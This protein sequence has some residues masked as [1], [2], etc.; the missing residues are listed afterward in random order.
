MRRHVLTNGTTNHLVTKNNGD[1]DHRRKRHNHERLQETMKISRKIIIGFACFG[2]LFLLIIHS[3][4]FVVVENGNY[5]RKPSESIRI[6]DPKRKETNHP[7]IEEFQ[8]RHFDNLE[9][10]QL[11]P[12]RQQVDYEQYT[13]RVNTW[14]RPEQLVASVLHHSSCPGVIQVQIVWCDTE[15]EPPKDLLDPSINPH[16]SKVV[17]EYHP[18]NNLNE[19]FNILLE[20]PTLGI[21]SIDDDVLRPCESIDSGFFKWIKSPH[22][23]VGFDAR[24]HVENKDKTWSYGYLRYENV[25]FMTQQGWFHHLL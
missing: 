24:T 5:D 17:I 4:L 10:I 9:P 7:K 18:T 2:F 8:V 20:P 21:L 15:N 11:T 14:R 25:S 22:R 3:Y 13:V 6:V 12:L 23:M 1:I 16:A 19:R